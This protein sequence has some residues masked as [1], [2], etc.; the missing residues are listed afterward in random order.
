MFQ[1]INTPGTPDVD[2]AQR[3]NSETKS[4]KVKG[5]GNGRNEP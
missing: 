2:M 4:T 1:K 5:A 3:Q